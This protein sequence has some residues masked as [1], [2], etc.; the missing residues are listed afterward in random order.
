MAEQLRLDTNSPKS[1]LLKLMKNSPLSFKKLSPDSSAKRKLGCDKKAVKKDWIENLVIRYVMKIVF[2]DSLIEKIADNILNLLSTESSK[3][4]QLSARL[5][6]INRSINNLLNAIQQGILTPSTKQRLEELEEAKKDI[7]TAIVCEKLQ[8]PEITKPHIIHFIKKFR[9][10]NFD[11]TNSQKRLI[12]SFVN[13]IYLY[14]DKIL[15]SFNYNDVSHELTLAELEAEIGSNFNITT[16]PG[17][18][19]F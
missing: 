16:P 9:D 15:F 6:E 11:D 13:S 2:D 14:D 3:I 19:R 12:D 10:M 5:K 1:K 4:P 7:E 18:V 8:R 17:N